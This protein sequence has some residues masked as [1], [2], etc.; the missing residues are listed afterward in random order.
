MDASLINVLTASVDLLITLSISGEAAGASSKRESRVEAIDMA[1]DLP[2]EQIDDME[3]I[4]S[5]WASSS[6]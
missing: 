2:C 4:R 3:F 1:V 5:V 6:F